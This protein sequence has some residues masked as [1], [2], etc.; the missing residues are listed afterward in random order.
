MGNQLPQRLNAATQAAEA[1]KGILDN[2]AVLQGL[3][4]RLPF[5]GGFADADFTGTSLSYLDAATIVALLTT[6]T[7][8]LTTYITDTAGTP[9]DTTGQVMQL[10]QQVAG[11]L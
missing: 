7:T 2:L 8:K 9:I 6:G 3:Q 5:L 1:C 10:L 11:T 4:T